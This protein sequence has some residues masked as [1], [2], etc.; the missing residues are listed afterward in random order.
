MTSPGLD[1]ADFPDIPVR[2]VWGWGDSLPQDSPA[3][4]R[5]YI[6]TVRK[7]AAHRQQITLNWLPDQGI[8][9]NGHMLMMEN[10]N[11]A[12]AQRAMDG[13]IRC[14]SKRR[15]R[16]RCPRFPRAASDAWASQAG[17]SNL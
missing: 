5:K 16:G 2:V 17:G 11:G 12:L 8:A 10:N 1:D 9:G 3:L 14:T 4:S 7:M 13:F 15:L 6:D